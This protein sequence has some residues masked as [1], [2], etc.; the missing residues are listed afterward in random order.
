MLEDDSMYFILLTVK[1]S[2]TWWILHNMLC[3]LIP[4]PVLSGHG[5]THVWDML[6]IN[7]LQEEKH[8][9]RVTLDQIQLLICDK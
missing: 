1:T 7:D 8:K 9:A 3:M 6:S 4:S 2:K 5:S